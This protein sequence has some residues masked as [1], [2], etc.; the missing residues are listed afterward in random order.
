[1]SETIDTIEQAPV[2]IAYD[3]S[4]HA[5]RAIRV[6]SREL[7]PGR[8]AIVLTVSQPP[9]AAFALGGVPP[10]PE[11][12][13][14]QVDEEALEVATEGARLAK[15]EGFDATPLVRQGS[16]IWQQIVAAADELDASIVVLGSHG[17]SGISAMLIGS[18]AE[19]VAR[20]TDRSVMIVHLPSSDD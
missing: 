7:R 15:D 10:L 18:V 12:L 13:Q 3:G 14:N 6:A 4:D 19:G 9:G 20:H 8:R 17:R 1:V 16:P 11:D 2:L 5:K